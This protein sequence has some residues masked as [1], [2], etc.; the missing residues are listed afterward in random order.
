MQVFDHAPYAATDGGGESGCD[1]GGGGD[2]VGGTCGACVEA[3]PTNPEHAS[4]G[5]TEDHGV[6]WHGFTAVAAAFAEEDAEDEGGPT[7]GHVDDDS[8]GEIDG[9]DRGILHV[10]KAAECAILAP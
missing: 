2:A 5:H 3:V 9:M 1:E 4:A 8:A 10:E 6:W 7:A